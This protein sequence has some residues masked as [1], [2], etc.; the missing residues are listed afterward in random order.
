MILKTLTS[1]TQLLP[2]SDRLPCKHFIEDVLQSVC[3]Y[4]HSTAL[5]LTCVSRSIMKDSLVIRMYF[6]GNDS[7]H[8]T[9]K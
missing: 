8:K 9:I 6:S 1:L 5:L 4:C 2:R 7:T 3:P